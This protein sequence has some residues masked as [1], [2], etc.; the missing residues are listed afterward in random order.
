MTKQYKCTKCR[1][2]K[3]ENDFHSRPPQRVGGRPVAYHCKECRSK[4]KRDLEVLQ[5]E[6]KK[7]GGVCRACERPRKLIAN[8][9][10]RECLEQRGLRQC[11][12]CNEVRLVLMDFWGTKGMCIQCC[13]AYLP[14]AAKHAERLERESRRLSM[15]PEDYLIDTRLRAIYKITLADYNRMLAAQDGKCAICHLPPQRSR[16]FVDHCHTSGKVRGLLCGKCNSA[17]GLLKDSVQALDEAKRY[18][19]SRESEA[20]AETHPASDACAQNPDSM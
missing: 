20:C 4:R 18:L 16:L 8:T 2:T 10:C 9:E 5:R 17:L 11:S 15:S 6:L 7:W 14:K 1:K 19:T 3:P 13:E 12:R